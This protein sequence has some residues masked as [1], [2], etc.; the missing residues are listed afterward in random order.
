MDKLKILVVDDET[1]MRKLVKDFLVK[2]NYDV[3]EAEDGEKAVDIFFKMNESN[4]DV[5]KLVDELNSN[6]KAYMDFACQRRLNADSADKIWGYFEILE[7]KLRE[8]I[9]NI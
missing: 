3:I 9:A 4:P 5:I 2:S 6:E 8:I 7:N 1:R